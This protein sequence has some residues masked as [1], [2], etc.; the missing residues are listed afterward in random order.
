M[1]NYFRNNGITPLPTSEEQRR[2]LQL[3]LQ[4]QRSLG[5]QQ[6]QEKD[7][8]WSQKKEQFLQRQQQKGRDFFQVSDWIERN[9]M[10]SM[11]EYLIDQ[12]LNSQ[13]PYVNP[14]AN[15]QGKQP[16]MPQ[17]YGYFDPSQQ[18]QQQQMMSQAPKGMQPMR[19]I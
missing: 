14:L 19:R 13:Y 4:Q 7:D 1:L 8:F 18:Q 6:P 2:Q 10:V 5:G 12:N 11:D 3:K 17:S 16:L 15:F 9:K